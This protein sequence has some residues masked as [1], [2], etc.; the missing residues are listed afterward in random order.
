LQDGPDE[1]DVGEVELKHFHQNIVQ[2]EKKSR[3]NGKNYSEK[4]VMP[5]YQ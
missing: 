1:D 3:K 4:Q 5:S 2:R